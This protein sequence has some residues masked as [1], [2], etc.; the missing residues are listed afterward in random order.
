MI[1]RLL[2]FRQ[3]YYYCIL[4]IIYIIYT[5]AT[6]YF[7]YT[8]EVFVSSFNEQ[9][10]IEQIHLIF[11]MNQSWSYIGYL[12]IPLFII[13]RTLFTSFC[14]YTGNLIREYHWDYKT[15]FNISLK[16]D[17]AF[18]ISVMCNFYYYVFS[19]DYHILQDLSV[20]FLSLLK[21]QK[22]IPE[23]LFFA[24]N[25][26]NVFELLYLILLVTMIHSSFRVAYSKSSIFVLLTYGVGNYCYI[27]AVTFIYLNF[28]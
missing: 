24:F 7:L 17:V 16:A 15:I 27:A 19:K 8:K 13:I 20:N 9:Y 2:R 1:N 3:S 18:C 11:K 4:V 22:S 28:A 12:L 25:S 5:Y 23:W 10:T 6:N 26:I 14:L 21:Y